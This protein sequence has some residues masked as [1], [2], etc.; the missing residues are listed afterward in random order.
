MYI[1][2]SLS[3]SLSLYIYIY[4]YKDFKA[5]FSDL[6]HVVLRRLSGILPTSRLIVIFHSLNY[7]FPPISLFG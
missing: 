4:I 3:L 7:I 2:I 5:T 1:Y 6:Q